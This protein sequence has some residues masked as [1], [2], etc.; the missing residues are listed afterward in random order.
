LQKTPIDAVVDDDKGV[1]ALG[2]A[3][4]PG[5]LQVIEYLVDLEASSEAVGRHEVMALMKAVYPTF[6]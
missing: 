6:V 4:V 1:T 3:A 5:R 2:L